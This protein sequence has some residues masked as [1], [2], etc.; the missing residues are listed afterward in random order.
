MGPDLEVKVFIFK[1][2]IQGENKMP[3]RD[4]KNLFTHARHQPL[5]GT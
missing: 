4:I 5:E 2:G 1:N 3:I